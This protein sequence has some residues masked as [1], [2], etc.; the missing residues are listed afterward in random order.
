MHRGQS[1]IWAQSHNWYALFWPQSGSLSSTNSVLCH[2]NP[3]CW[4]QS[5]LSSTGGS[6][7]KGTFVPL[8]TKPGQLQESIN[9]INE[10]SMTSPGLSWGAAIIL[11]CKL[12]LTGSL[13]SCVR[14]WDQ[15]SLRPD[16]REQPGV[17]AP[18]V[19]RTLCTLSCWPHH[20]YHPHPCLDHWYHHHG[21][22]LCSA[23]LSKIIKSHM[24]MIGRCGL[25]SWVLCAIGRAAPAL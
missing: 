14:G 16:I 9:N 1:P 7:P 3:M 17:S 25:Q 5:D 13:K 8:W 21:S 6:S 4:Y 24:K 11:S 2:S 19:P 22:G 20:K 15:C 12:L 23:S 10:H 18:R